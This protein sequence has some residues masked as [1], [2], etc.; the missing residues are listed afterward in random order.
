MEGYGT[1]C[2]V[3]EINSAKN[4]SMNME[5]NSRVFVGGIPVRVEKQTILDFFS[6]FGA[7]KYCKIKKNSKTGRSLGYAYI[8][9]EDPQAVHQLINKQIEFCGRICECKPV[10]KKNK[11]KEE[12]AKEKRKKLLV[13]NIDPTITNSELQEYFEKMTAINYA[14][15]VKDPE[16]KFNK[17]YGYVV[18]NSEEELDGFFDEHPVLVLKGKPFLSSNKLTVPPKKKK[19]LSAKAASNA[20]EPLK[21]ACESRTRRGSQ[22][23]KG[24]TQQHSQES[25]SVSVADSDEDN[26]QF[27]SP[28]R[29]NSKNGTPDWSQL[30]MGRS[31][32]LSKE[33]PQ[34]AGA[35]RSQDA[36]LLQKSIHKFHI[37]NSEEALNNGTEATKST[38]V[39]KLPAKRT[40]FS[41][42][43]AMKR[44]TEISK[45][46]K[47]INQDLTN[48]RFN[49]PE[50]AQ[51]MDQ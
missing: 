7:I 48:Y 22:K 9:F 39:A 49:K 20:G 5:P 3:V 37:S 11:L 36:Y 27:S 30:Q 17:G 38:R 2:A 10:F 4:T 29:R 50:H 12:L 25:E 42:F 47:T 33:L 6:Q 41:S 28:D 34:L 1:I 18:F 16:N 44:R 31:L 14:F 23:P 35:H 8:T 51:I 15:V 43:E 26:S 24:Q 40:H 19:E 13:Y 21:K 32:H 46:S 45:M